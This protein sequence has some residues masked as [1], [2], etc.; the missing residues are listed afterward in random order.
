MPG[1]KNLMEKTIFKVQHKREKPGYWW[2]NK[3]EH[4]LMRSHW[5]KR[6]LSTL[7][8][9]AWQEWEKRK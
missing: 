2:I 1:R 3:D 8:L 5:D 9:W 6:G 7:D 4:D